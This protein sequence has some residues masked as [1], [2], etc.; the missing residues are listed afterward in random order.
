[1]GTPYSA[2]IIKD[3]DLAL[4]ALEIVY[5]TNGTSVD[6]I[7]DINGHRKKEVGKEKIFSWGGVQTKGEGRECKLTKKM[8]FHNDL[9]QLCLEKT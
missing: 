6:G 3:L 9:L 8:F 4:K 7:A 1:M 5:R 2:G